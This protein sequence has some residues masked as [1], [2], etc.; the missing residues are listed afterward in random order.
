MTKNELF[1]TETHMPTNM[2]AGIA[3][4]TIQGVETKK[5][6]C[7]IGLRVVASTALVKASG[8]DGGGLMTPEPL[9]YLM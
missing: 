1:P 5:K 4:F 7:P 3:V 9:S 6:P 2:S 8:R